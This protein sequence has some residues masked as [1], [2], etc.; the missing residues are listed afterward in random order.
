MYK[1]VPACGR[2]SVHFSLGTVDKISKIIP[3]L[4]NYP[5]VKVYTYQSML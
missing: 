3:R 5:T 2:K 4:N 1:H